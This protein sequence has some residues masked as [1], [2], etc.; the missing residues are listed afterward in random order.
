MPFR[1][2]F[3]VLLIVFVVVITG[4]N[5]DNKCNI[6]LFHTFE[7]VPVIATILASFVTGVIVTLPSVFIH[8]GKKSAKTEVEQ[9]KEPKVKKDKPLFAKKDKTTAV[10]TDDKVV[11]QPVVNSI[12]T[13][14]KTN[15]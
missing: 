6:W 7:E 2:I 15:Q 3:T 8:R 12:N 1:L 4:F 10:K 9:K 13:D 11:E 14:Y 5:L